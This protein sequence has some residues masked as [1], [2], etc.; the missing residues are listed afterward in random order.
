[1]AHYFT[2]GNE[3]K[4]KTLL[5]GDVD[6]VPRTPLVMISFFLGGIIVSNII[7][8]LMLIDEEILHS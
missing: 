8:A 1:M 2:N 4:S 6:N 3:D 7:M 5:K